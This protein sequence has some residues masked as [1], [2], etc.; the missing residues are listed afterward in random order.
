MS[1]SARAAY[2][3]AA[4][5]RALAALSIEEI[6]DAA[7]ARG[8][9]WLARRF[10]EMLARIP[11][12]RLGATLARFDARIAVVGIGAAAREVMSAFGATVDVRGG[13]PASGSVLVV[14]NH[15]GAYDSLATMAALGR[16]D[17]AL[18]AADRAFLRAMPHLSGH[19]VFVADSRTRGSAVGR[20][21]GL[22]SALAWLGAGHA[23]VHYGAGAIEPDTAFTKPGDEVL[24]AWSAGTGLL[25]LRAAALGAAVVP[26]LV[27]G[28]HSRRAKSLPLMRWAERRGVT[29]IAPLVQATMPGFRDVSA[30]VRFGTPIAAGELLRAPTHVAR[31]AQL[32]AAVAAL[33]AP[34]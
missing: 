18:V 22:R 2:D 10:V 3:E 11:S 25:A 23:L 4:V 1:P 16:D 19:L 17:V 34:R 14:T 15:P 26:A 8:A 28:V 29:T 20:A 27:W 9:P 32:R 30:C 12:G 13:L 24:G 21:A 33:V 5:A 7:A 6:V 31:T